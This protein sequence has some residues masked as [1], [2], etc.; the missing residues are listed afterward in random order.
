MDGDA[1]GWIAES[2]RTPDDAAA[3]PGDAEDH[4]STT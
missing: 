3:K 2:A 1:A 4:A